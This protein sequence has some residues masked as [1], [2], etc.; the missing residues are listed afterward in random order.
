MYVPRDLA[1]KGYGGY[2]R[3]CGGGME[4]RKGSSA[5]RR[6]VDLRA[7]CNRSVAA[8]ILEERRVKE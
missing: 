3:Q 5:A 6:R 7:P 1:C 4:T 8:I 2:V